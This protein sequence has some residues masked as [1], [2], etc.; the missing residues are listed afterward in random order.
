MSKIVRLDIKNFRTIKSLSETF[1]KNFVC[2]IGRNDCGKTTVLNSIYYVLYPNYTLQFYDTDFFNSNINQQIQIEV[3]LSEIPDILQTEEKFGLYKRQYNR[4]TKEI[5]D[6]LIDDDNLEDVYTIR[7]TVDK[8][9]EPKWEIVTNRQEPKTISATDRAKLNCFF[10]SDYVDNHFSWNKGSPLYQLFKEISEASENSNIIIDR[11]RAVKSDID[12]IDFPQTLE[13]TNEISRTATK[14]GLN[15]E[16]LKTSID[17][18]D[19]AIKDTKI[20]LNDYNNIPLRLRGKGAKRVF[21]MAIQLALTKQGG[22]VLI[23]EIEQGLEP[24]RIKQI[25]S[26]LKDEN[27]GQIF[28]TTHSRDAVV[29]LASSDLYL[30]KKSDDN[31]TVSITNIPEKDNWQS[32]VRANPEGFFCKKMIVCEG[33]TEIG[34][35]RALDKW[36]QKNNKGSMSLNDCFYILGEG[37]TSIERAKK[38]KELG[39]DTC[40]FIDSDKADI[41]DKKADLLVLGIK[42]FDCENGNDIEHQIFKDLPWSIIEELLSS[43]PSVTGLQDCPEDRIKIANYAI[44]KGNEWYKRIDK[45][46]DLGKIIFDKWDTIPNCHTKRTWA[47]LSEWIGE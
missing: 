20:C 38:L 21:S 26:I 3:T 19:I 27:N 5:I 44:D 2:L 40:V 22:I 47:A 18:R 41:N 37:S 32:I 14:L 12:N 7:L 25:V 34:I 11:L 6:D 24:D 1:D 23:D 15:A 9:L 33:K 29:E 42:I 36:R 31:K 17:F 39:F 35:C 28:L 16:G 43:H 4:N 13:T 8:T 45:G 46:D 10:I 30:V